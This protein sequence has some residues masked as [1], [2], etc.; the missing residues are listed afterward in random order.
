MARSLNKVILIGY[1]ADEPVIRT[2]DN[3]GKVANVT[4][5][6]NEFVRH[7]D[8]T[9]EEI[10]EW[11]RIVF[12]NSTANIV[13][14]YVHKG[15][16]LYVEGKLRTR[17]YTDKT[18]A[19]RYTTEIYAD[20]M[21]MLDSRNADASRDFGDGSNNV[22]ANN[23][24]GTYNRPP[25]NNQGYP[26]GNQRTYGN[27][28]NN[29]YGGQNTPYGGQSTPYGG[30]STPYGG[31]NTPYGGQNTPYGGP[32][33]TFGNPNTFG[34]NPGNNL[35]P[36]PNQPA[37]QPTNFQGQGGAYQNTTWD[38]QVPA[39]PTAPATAPS[40]FETPAAPAAPAAPS[41]PQFDNSTYGG[42]GGTSTATTVP[43]SF[44]AATAGSYGN[45]S[46]ASEAAP[47]APAAGDASA[48]APSSAP[49]AAPAVTPTAAPVTDNSNDDDIPF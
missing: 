45:T 5:V 3:G 36:Y 27:Q 21:I 1:T 6:T 38:N 22:R 30:Q 26:Y 7:Q 37:S 9:S 29:P 48:A 18:G 46:F 13:E 12:W 43:G 40:S 11:N 8:G 28:G 23:T 39:A 49:A 16:R 32:G 14:T 42:L 47:A 25:Y 24:N 34:N 31:Q 33:N 2:F 15:M 4:V 17:S 35:P 41:Y 10:P 44:D 20:N 19:K